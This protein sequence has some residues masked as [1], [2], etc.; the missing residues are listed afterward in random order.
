MRAPPFGPGCEPR[1]APW[2]TSYARVGGDAESGLGGGRPQPASGRA[3]RAL[4]DARRRQRDARAITKADRRLLVQCRRERRCCTVTTGGMAAL[5]LR[6]SRRR[7]T[8]SLG[9]RQSDQD[10]HSPPRRASFRCEVASAWFASQAGVWC[11]RRFWADQPAWSI[12]A[13]S[14]SADCGP[15]KR[16]TI[17]PSESRT[18][19]LG[20]P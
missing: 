9:A 18:K 14:L 7:G 8:A 20:R 4:E 5:R 15:I 12:A 3:C 19:P 2:A 16:L 13:T 10:L 17:R 11:A 6:R 1:P